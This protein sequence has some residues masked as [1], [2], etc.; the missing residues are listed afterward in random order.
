MSNAVRRLPLKKVMVT[1][2]DNY[3]SSTNYNYADVVKSNGSSYAS[4]ADNN[5]GNPVSDTSKWFKLAEKG[6]TYEV[7]EEDL[8]VIEEKITENANSAFNRNADEKVS[9][10]NTNASEKTATYD[11]NHTAKLKKYNDNASTSLSSYN[12]NA[13]AAVETYNTNA[14]SKTTDFNTNASTKTNSF[15]ENATSKTNAFNSNVE[16]KTQ[17]F[18][19]NANSILLILGL[20][21]D[22]YDST[23]TYSYKEQ[24]IYNHILWESTQFD[25]VGN[26]PTTNSDY[27]KIVPV[28]ESE[29]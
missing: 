9:A 11:S 5:I 25:N 21:T 2:I 10:F 16:A 29:E 3:D 27:W 20:S 14:N 1:F 8:Q 4:K 22:D 26:I 7:S 17:E 19:D 12:S 13:S 18:N 23:K 24:T 6:D 15:N 28:L